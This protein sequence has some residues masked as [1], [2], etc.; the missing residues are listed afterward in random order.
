MNSRTQIISRGYNEY[1]LEILVE[2]AKPTWR[3]VRRWVEGDY[4]F[5]EISGLTRHMR[6]NS[7]GCLAI[8]GSFQRNFRNL[9][10]STMCRDEAVEWDEQELLSE[11]LDDVDMLESND[12]SE[13]F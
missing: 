5:I 10:Y 7:T 6:R 1:G 11:F 2:V 13:W 4:L 9:V 12:I 3:E 8:Y